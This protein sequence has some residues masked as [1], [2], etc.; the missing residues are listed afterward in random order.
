MNAAVFL[1][2]LLFCLLVA[3]ECNFEV[4]SV[5]D[6]EDTY[7]N[8][9]VIN[10]LKANSGEYKK[11]EDCFKSLSPTELVAVPKLNHYNNCVTVPTNR[12]CLLSLSSNDIPKVHNVTAGVTAALCFPD[13][14]PV[15]TIER[16]I[17]AYICTKLFCNKLKEVESRDMCLK[18]QRIVC[19]L[20]KYFKV[21]PDD[22]LF[23]L[24]NYPQIDSVISCIPTN[25]T[26][27]MASGLINDLGDW[28]GCTHITDQKYCVVNYKGVT[29]SGKCG[30]KTCGAKSYKDITDYVC[31]VNNSTGP[32]L[33]KQPHRNMCGTMMN[34]LD[35]KDC[36][37]IDAVV[38]SDFPVNGLEMLANDGVTAK[39][40]TLYPDVTW[41]V[42]AFVGGLLLV[43]ILV[44]LATCLGS[45]VVP[46]ETL[47]FPRLLLSSFDWTSNWKILSGPPG[48]FKCL[49]ALKLIAICWIILAHTFEYYM[50]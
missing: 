12:Y 31:T 41:P 29:T 3:V 2:L 7:F 38:C 14:C 8:P 37:L 42:K 15:K 26:A 11:I 17:D 16:L 13:S 21:V 25:D 33:T 27:V 30:P 6:G 22:N 1:L 44:I 36:M 35:V 5:G 9:F 24:D 19:P 39:C 43:I 23:C 46:T 28:R 20:Q 34:V 47:H 10:D 50:E 45:G 18:I 40:G 48:M 32:L 4:D 49:D